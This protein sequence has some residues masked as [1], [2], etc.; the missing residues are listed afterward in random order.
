[1]HMGDSLADR[2]LGYSR[3]GLVQCLRQL[4]DDLENLDTCDSAESSGVLL[5]DWALMERA[6]PCLVGRPIGH[7]GIVDGRAACTSQLFYIDEN[8][9]VARTLSRWYRLAPP[10]HTTRRLRQ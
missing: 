1:M 5:M 9:G 10:G 6:V 8:R 7:P 4:A 3:S 2:F